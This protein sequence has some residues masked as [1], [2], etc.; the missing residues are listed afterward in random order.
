MN[1]HSSYA[2]GKSPAKRAIRKVL[3]TVHRKL[4]QYFYFDD[5]VFLKDLE[6]HKRWDIG[7][8]THGHPSKSPRIVNCNEH[9]TL[10]IGNYCSFAE[11]VMIV[12]GSL[13]HGAVVA[14]YPFIDLFHGAEE[15]SGTSRTGGTVVI[16]NDVTVCAGAMILS[17]VTIG[18]GVVV[19]AG[20]VVTKDVSAYTIVAGNPAAPVRKRFPDEIVDELE[21][22]QWWNWPV[23]KIRS[24]FPVLLSADV[25]AFLR[26]NGDQRSVEHLLR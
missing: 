6:R 24:E 19:A 7:E 14:N 16:G 12:F 9:C 21:H 15:A 8:Y 18:N 10:K 20:S 22:I 25:Q 3:H 13:E 2:Q 11:N 26:R 17:G 1:D 5:T 4:H 23:D